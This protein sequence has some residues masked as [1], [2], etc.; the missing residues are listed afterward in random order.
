MRFELLCD[1]GDSGD[2]EELGVAMLDLATVWSHEDEDTYATTL[3]C[4]FVVFIARSTHSNVFAVEN[5]D[6]L[7]V[8]E[9][10]ISLGNLIELHDMLP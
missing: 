5:A 2:C 8:A 6:R 7:T 1:P 4:T 9:V 3:A 10:D